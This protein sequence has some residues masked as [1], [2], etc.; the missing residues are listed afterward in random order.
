M[1]ELIV[2]W[3]I[4]IG[5]CDQLAVTSTGPTVNFNLMALGTYRSNGIWN[6]KTSYKNDNDNDR[7]LHL[8]PENNWMVS[9][10]WYT[11]L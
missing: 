4:L 6:G 7:Y 5:C 3:Y 9:R 2:N 10:Q 11:R 8:N 1:T